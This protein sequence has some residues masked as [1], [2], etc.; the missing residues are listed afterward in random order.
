M[1]SPPSPAVDMWETIYHQVMESP[2]AIVEWISSTGLRPYL[3]SLDAGEERRHFIS[4]LV[5]RVA[6]C[7]PQRS[8]GTVLFPFRRL[9]VI[10]YS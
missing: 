7:Y 2:A 9:S 5:K 8:D 1:C 10:A 6:S 4:L 3:D